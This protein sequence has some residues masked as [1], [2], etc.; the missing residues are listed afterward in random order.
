M[1]ADAGGGYPLG[2]EGDPGFALDAQEAALGMAGPQGIGGAAL[3]PFLLPFAH[4]PLAVAGVLADP[5]GTPGHDQPARRREME[6][7][8]PAVTMG[9]PPVATL[10]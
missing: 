5:P 1:S 8:D 6:H 2:V 9:E 3:L 7:A 4:R 10:G